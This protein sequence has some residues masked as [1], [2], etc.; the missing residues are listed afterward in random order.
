MRQ[1]VWGKTFLRA[2]KKVVDHNPN[3]KTAIERTLRLLAADPFDP[4]L[5]NHKLRGK[6]EGTW[7]SSV[8]YDVRLVFQFVKSAG[9]E[10]DIFLI[11]VGSH[12]EVY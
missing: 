5:S 3:L 6:L 12:E 1:L 7:A 11:E 4:R 8:G 9:K 2:C 10:D